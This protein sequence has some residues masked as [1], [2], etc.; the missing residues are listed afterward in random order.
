M[1]L[2]EAWHCKKPVLVNG[3]CEVLKGQCIRSNAGLW[4]ENYEEFRECLDLL[5]ADEHLRDQLGNRGRKFVDM[6]YS[7]ENIEN[8]YLNLIKMIQK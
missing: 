5:L 1:V 4:Y 3:Q 8:K 7:W 2:L 6:N